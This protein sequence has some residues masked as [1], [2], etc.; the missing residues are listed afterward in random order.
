MKT[1]DC[2]S[3]SQWL[4]F[5]TFTAAAAAATTTTR[6]R[7]SRIVP[8]RSRSSCY[9]YCYCYCFCSVYSRYRCPGSFPLWLMLAITPRLSQADDACWG[10]D[11]FL[12][13]AE[14]VRTS[15]FGGMEH[16]FSFLG[17]EGFARSL[18]LIVLK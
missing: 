16:L 2:C 5:T 7:R 13:R 3:D 18:T 14:R 8:L 17:A 1:H 4:W 12:P 9:C 6:T 15:G 10:H 11:A